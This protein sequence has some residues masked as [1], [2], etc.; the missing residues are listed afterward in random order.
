MQERD[1][2]SKLK[3][4]IKERFP[5]SVILKNDPTHKQGIPDLLVLYKDRWGALEVKRSE[6]AK[7][8]PNQ[9]LRVEKLNSMSFSAIIFPENEKEVLDAME[10]SFSRRS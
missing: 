2:Q 6:K 8:R 4:K 9:S 1:Y 5:G 3:K 7:E 10:Q